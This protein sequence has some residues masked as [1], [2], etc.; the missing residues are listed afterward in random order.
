M[1]DRGLLTA[2]EAAELAALE[3]F[4]VPGEWDRLYWLRYRKA[5]VMTW[6]EVKDLIAAQLPPD[7]DRP[8][9]WIEKI[10]ADRAK[11]D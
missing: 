3:T 5:G 8:S 1:T 11:G 6:R 7:D 9:P 10:F 4:C 2:D